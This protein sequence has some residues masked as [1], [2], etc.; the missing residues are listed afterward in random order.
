VIPIS[1]LNKCDSEPRPLGS[2]VFSTFELLAVDGEADSLLAVFGS[3]GHRQQPARR[4]HSVVPDHHFRDAAAGLAFVSEDDAGLGAL[5]GIEA[6]GVPLAAEWLFGSLLHVA[7]VAPV[8]AGPVLDDVGLRRLHSAAVVVDRQFDAAEFDLFA[9]F[10]L[11][12]I[13]R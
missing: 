12:P 10:D 4:Q 5:H 3:G 2:G 8:C 1:L 6:G 9:E 7:D 13:S 11:Q